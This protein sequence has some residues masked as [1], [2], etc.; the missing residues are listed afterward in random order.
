MQA[1]GQLQTCMKLVIIGYTFVKP[2]TSPFPSK[3]GG[4]PAQHT[5][6]SVRLIEGPCTL[7]RKTVIAAVRGV[8]QE[9]LGCTSVTM[10]RLN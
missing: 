10:N 8:Y 2:A 3:L 6:H 9:Q 1:T 4:G 7:G 5:T